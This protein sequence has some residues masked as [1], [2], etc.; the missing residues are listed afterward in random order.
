MRNNLI[1]LK[2]WDLKEVSDVLNS[3]RYALPCSGVIHSPLDITMSYIDLIKR[4]MT[5]YQLNE[6]IYN[7]SLILYRSPGSLHFI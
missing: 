6:T 4:N 5:D 1:I 7:L 3:D 2:R